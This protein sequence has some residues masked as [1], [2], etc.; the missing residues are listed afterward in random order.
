MKQI[1]QKSES[2]PKGGFS[3]IR[4]RFGVLGA[5]SFGIVLTPLLGILASFVVV[6]VF[7]TF[8]AFKIREFQD[9]NPRSIWL[10]RQAMDRMYHNS[11]N[12][13][14]IASQLKLY[15]KKPVKAKTEAKVVKNIES[16]QA[17]FNSNLNLA[18]SR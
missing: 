8:I 17:K 11:V 12:A 15:E 14:Y 16:K 4:I 10:H 9:N 2:P 1:K 7:G 6:I 13:K 18:I 3:D 5:M